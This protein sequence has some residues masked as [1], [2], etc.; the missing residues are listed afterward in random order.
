ME[1]N[2]NSTT[3]RVHAT[4]QRIRDACQR[5]GRK[6]EDMQLIAVS[7]TY[8]VEEIKEALS[9]GICHIGENKVQEAKEKLPALQKDKSLSHVQWHYIGHLQTNKVR[10]AV[11]LFDIIHSVDSLRLAAEIDRRSYTKD[12]IMPV[13]IQVNTSREK[14]KY[15]ID[16]DD[17]LELVKQ[18]SELKNVK[19]KGLMTIGALTATTA[20]DTVKIRSYFRKLRELREF[21]AGKN[22]PNVDMDCLSMGMSNDFEI[23]IEEGATHLR[24]G[25]AIFGKRKRAVK[26][27]LSAASNQMEEKL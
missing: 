18:V 6:P 20:N 23:A 13:L 24:I 19:I 11:E 5:S 22:I 17:T 8:G 21:I 1:S 10:Q 2:T 3:Y 26:S 4:L 7:K 12:K 15:G 27:L 14:S 16:P 9:A 25:T